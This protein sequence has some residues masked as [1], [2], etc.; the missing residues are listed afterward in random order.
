MIWK[1]KHETTKR[2]SIKGS[3]LLGSPRYG[4]AMKH[5]LQTAVG[6][7]SGLCTC[8]RL[9]LLLIPSHKPLM[10]QPPRPAHKCP[11]PTLVPT[12][13]FPF[14]FLPGADREPHSLLLGQVFLTQNGSLQAPPLLPHPP[15]P[16]KFLA[17]GFAAE[18]SSV[19]VVPGCQRLY[20]SALL[21]LILCNH[22]LLQNLLA[23]R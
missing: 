11:L 7:R 19:S 6:G 1:P 17:L 18:L 14:T 4:R 9:G 23:A 12:P 15:L 20:I 10:E 8:D 3:G 5:G 16:Q 2:H 13:M 22:F 21:M